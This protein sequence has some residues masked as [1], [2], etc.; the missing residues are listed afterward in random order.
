VGALAYAVGV[1]LHELR[2]RANDLEA[3]FLQLTGEGAQS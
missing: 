1:E 3:V 2:P